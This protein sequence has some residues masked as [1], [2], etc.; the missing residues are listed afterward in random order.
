MAQ[1]APSGPSPLS[2]VTTLGPSNPLVANVSIALASTE[3]SY[4]IP[5]GSRRF[6]LKARGNTTIQLA[7]VS[8]DSGTTYLTIPAGTFYSEGDLSLTLGKTIY[9]QSTQAGQILEI[10]SWS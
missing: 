3:Y 9:F 1:F 5:A 8:G 4:F 10:V 2:T 7:F 6:L